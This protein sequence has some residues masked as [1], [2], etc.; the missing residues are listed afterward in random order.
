MTTRIES[1]SEP[2]L[3]TA[4][5]KKIGASV[6]TGERWTIVTVVLCNRDGTD[7]T[8]T[9]WRVDAGSPNQKH[10]ILA[11]YSV[12]A[13]ETKSPPVSQLMLE[14]GWSLHAMASAGDAVTFNATIEKEIAGV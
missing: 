3:L 12:P 2:L 10:K 5:S 7:R 9:L 11:G 13:G 14:P 6:P 1:L 8:V 4:S